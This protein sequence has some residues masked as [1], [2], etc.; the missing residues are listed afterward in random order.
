M[1][2]TIFLLL[3]AVTALST[4]QAREWTDATGKYR[5]EAKLV[6]VH[7]DKV[8]LERPDGKII[9]IP[10]AKLSDEDQ[11]FLKELVAK[12]A[13][14]S[15][16][17]DRPADTQA[18]AAMSNSASALDMS[19]K[20]LATQT[21]ILLQ[22]ACH[23][24]HGEDGTSEGGF[25][26]VVNLGKLAETI[27]EPGEDSLLIE[28]IQADDDSVMPPGGEEPRLS[29]RDI[30][31]IQEWIA[32]GSPAINDEPER[33]FVSNDQVVALIDQ[34][35]QQQPERSQRFMRYFT[36]TH[37][38]NSG[39]SEDELQTYRNAFAKLL[40]SLSRAFL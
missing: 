17:S 20:Q 21:K 13:G 24:C 32:A 36:L 12:K 29:P 7:G 1:R 39:I 23:R 31:V 9:S 10:V 3:L 15:S 19:P 22:D 37:L 34:D 26:F 38:Y 6:V 5:I 33:P 14:P 30:Q 35:L 25:N 40:N 8:V 27:A 28:R 18:S 11:T 2:F 16:E 4:L